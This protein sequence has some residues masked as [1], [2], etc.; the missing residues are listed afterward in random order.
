MWTE[1]AATI[2]GPELSGAIQVRNQGA[3]QASLLLSCLS[4]IYL[5][6]EMVCAFERK[7]GFLGGQ[8]TL[9]NNAFRI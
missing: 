9:Q 6:V 5:N 7:F 2:C 4:R 3:I 1:R 8:G